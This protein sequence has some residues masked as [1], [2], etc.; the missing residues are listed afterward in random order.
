MDIF[1][2]INNIYTNKNSNW[3]IDLEDNEIQPFLINRFLANNEA[4]SSQ[5]RW[6]DAYTFVLPPKMWLSLAW[7]IVPKVKKAPYVP[8]AKKK[9]ETEEFDFILSRVRQY[10]L[11]ADN[12]FR[13]IKERLIKSIRKDMPM[14]FS[15]FG[16]EKNY[17]KRYHID[18]NMMKQFNVEEKRGLFGYE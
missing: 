17:W 3:I 8:F 11:M 10:F 9:D 16:I 1:Y 18:F 4:L 6:L 14:W 2:I 7:S 15:F 13:M 5:S 12:D